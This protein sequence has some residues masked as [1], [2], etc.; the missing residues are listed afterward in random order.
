MKIFKTLGKAVALAALNIATAAHAGLVNDVPSCYGAFHLAAAPQQPA[1]VVYVLI[2][3]TMLLDQSLQQ[4]VLDNVDR[5]IQPGAKFV[6][7]EFSAFA[8]AHYL[9]VLHT[10]YVEQPLPDDAYNTLPITKAPQIKACFGQQLAF[11]RKMAASTTRQAMAESTSTLNAS[12]IMAALG[13]LGPAVRNDAASDKVLFVVTD[14]L[15]N[16]RTSSF[17][18]HGGVRDISPGAELAKARANGMFADLGGAK[19]YVLGGAVMPPSSS[20]TQ[21]ERDGYRDSKTVHD[22]RAFWQGYFESSHAHLVEFGAP[23]L[24]TPVSY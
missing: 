8:Q 13:E 14:G 18:A 21:A 1:R 15:E 6:I 7:A 16:S 22:L 12:E 2:D 10:G 19:I 23:S 17:Y 24:V 20:G 11:A 5:L 4:S 9:K 3:Q